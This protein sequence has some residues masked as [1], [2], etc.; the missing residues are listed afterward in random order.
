MKSIE[1]LSELQRSP[2]H[3]GDDKDG[4]ISWKAA[5]QALK[6]FADDSNAVDFE[7]QDG[8][9]TAS[10]TWGPE[11]GAPY[12]RYIMFVRPHGDGQMSGML[13]GLYED[14]ELDEIQKFV[15]PRSMNGVNNAARIYMQVRS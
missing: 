6:Q 12:D 11:L 9:N 13:L 10:T 5:K 7:E 14:G 3:R 8:G 1:F 15:L 4:I 2:G